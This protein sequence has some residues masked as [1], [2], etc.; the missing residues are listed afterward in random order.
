[1]SRAAETADKTEALDDLVSPAV[2]RDPY[3]YLHRLRAHDPVHY[4]ARWKGW[5]M[6]SYEVIA[7][8][9]KI[10]ELS[11]DKYAPFS[12]LKAPTDDQKEV[13]G[14]LGL[15]LG[16]QDPPLHTRLRSAIAK[17]F[18]PRSTTML[19]PRMREVTAELLDRA[20]VKR[21]IDLID[22]LAYPLTTAVIGGLLGMPHE[23]LHRVDPWAQAIAP[24]MFMTPG[25]DDRYRHA[26]T[27]LDDMASYFGALLRRR[28]EDPREDLI[29]SLGRVM[30]AGEL[31]EREVLAT[32]MVVIF[33]GHETTKDLIGNGTLALIDHPEEL[34]KL[35]ANP[36]LTESAIEEM[37]RF[38]PPAKSTVRWA[39]KDVVI[40]NK[41]IKA[42]ERLL[43]FW[44]GANRDP[45][46]FKDP[47]RFD[48]TR[49]PNPHLGL[50]KGIH[51][52]IGAPLAR[53]EAA[54]AFPMLLER[55]KTIRLAVDHGQLEY[56]PTIIM[57][58]LKHL[59]LEVA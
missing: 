43:A 37:L 29:S 59:P 8:M 33:G 26:R 2:I 18:T 38:D 48:I 54:I 4:N 11:N 31:S 19:I 56:H 12:K 39:T 16:S 50:G 27:Q 17:A 35:R 5:V 58:G 24:I 52:C 40:G 45:A 3:A 49:S 34:S 22:D 30:K 47:D 41:A 23:D 21:E 42:G 57:R 32:C 25:G 7:S 13:F 44:A 6:T 46:Q 10:A 9:H 15:W 55:F 51:V 14:W 28:L 1:M 20:A 36:G 53:Q